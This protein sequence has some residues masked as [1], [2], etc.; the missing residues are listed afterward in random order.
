MDIADYVYFN[1]KGNCA[2]DG[3]GFAEDL[4]K[5]LLCSTAFGKEQIELIEKILGYK[6]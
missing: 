4:I 6:K 1:Q 3:N 5:I 2:F